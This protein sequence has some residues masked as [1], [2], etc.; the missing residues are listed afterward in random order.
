[1]ERLEAAPQ[2]LKDTKK[3]TCE[4]NITCGGHLMNPEDTTWNYAL[5]LSAE[6]KAS[7]KLP[8]GLITRLHRRPQIA[9]RLL[10]YL[11]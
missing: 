9:P 7:E 6:R 4:L 3:S 11:G 1:M 5:F 8:H 10:K 2:R